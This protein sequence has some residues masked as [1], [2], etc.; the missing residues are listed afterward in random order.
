M[1]AA[2]LLPPRFCVSMVIGRA[3]ASP[4]NGMG[5]CSGMPR[6]MPLLL[7]LRAGPAAAAAA[8]AA[9]PRLLVEGSAGK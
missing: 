1:G 2:L 6:N 9:P 7:L 3:T 5:V 8:A 4:A